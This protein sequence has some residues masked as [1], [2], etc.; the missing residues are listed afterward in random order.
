MICN[1]HQHSIT[2]AAYAKL[3]KTMHVLIQFTTYKS[4]H[5]TKFSHDTKKKHTWR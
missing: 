2:L 1:M 3:L 4:C 5:S